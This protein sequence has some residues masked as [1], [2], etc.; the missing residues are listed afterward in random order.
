MGAVR[1]DKGF[2]FNG[3]G[4]SDGVDHSPIRIDQTDGVRCGMLEVETACAVEHNQCDCAWLQDRCGLQWHV[5]LVQGQ[6]SACSLEF[7]TCNIDGF[8]A[9]VLDFQPFSKRPLL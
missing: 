2:T 5:V 3:G 6:R 4:P 1:G 8:I 7:P 9:T